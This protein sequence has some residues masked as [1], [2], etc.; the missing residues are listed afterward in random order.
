MI[1][2]AQDPHSVENRAYD[3]LISALGY[4][5][6]AIH[7]PTILAGRASHRIAVMF[8]ERNCLHFDLN[9]DWYLSNG[10]LLL[11]YDHG[12]FVERLTVVLTSIVQTPAESEI[13]ACIDISSMSR[14]MISYIILTLYK[15]CSAGSLRIRV[16]I[17][18]SPATFTAPPRDSWP[19]TRS[20]PVISQ[21]AGW[22]ELSAAS[23][24]V[25][26]GLGYEQDY[27]F[28]TAEYLEASDIWAFFPTGE[29]GQF[30]KAVQSANK[31]LL[32]I[33][34]PERTFKYK[35]GDPLTCFS[36]LDSLVTGILSYGRPIVVPLGP[37]I[38]AAVAILVAVR[39]Y[40]RVTVWRASGDQSAEALD[41]KANGKLVSFDVRFVGAPG[42]AA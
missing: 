8:T 22:S 2:I 4:E 27:A 12:T 17:V 6:R 23:P 3:V 40:P 10:F 19:I 36:V 20:E 26:V 16:T 29:D 39:H 1:E 34:G 37:K 32:D 41:R 14:P 35:V 25:I 11:P 30:D 5:A 33:I 7:A 13:R 28:G 42:T 15:L 38:F 31:I 24:Q 18:Y 21:L 9:K